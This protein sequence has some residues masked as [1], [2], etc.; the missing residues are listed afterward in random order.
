MMVE[1]EKANYPCPCCGYL[2]F[3]SP[4]GSDDI[5]K[6]CF[7]QDDVV[8]L[9]DPLFA[10]GPSPICLVEAQRNYALLGACEPRFASNVRPPGPSDRRDDGWRPLNVELDN[11]ER[12]LPEG[13]WVTPWPT[14]STQLYWWRDTYRRQRLSRI[15]DVDQTPKD[16][17]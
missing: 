3:S 2:M 8:L 4:P 17:A 6:I 5:C 9:R 14:D 1:T 16:P 12:C 11:P 10:G 7:W 13:G 15:T